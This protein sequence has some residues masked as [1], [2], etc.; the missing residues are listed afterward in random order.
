MYNKEQSRR[1][2]LES[3]G[4]VLI[5]FL[6]G[7]LPWQGLKISKEE[8]R[9]LKIYEKKKGTSPEELCEGVPGKIFIKS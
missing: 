3:F 4:Y 1:D 8:N 5:Y 7:S 2:D 9:Y 6:K